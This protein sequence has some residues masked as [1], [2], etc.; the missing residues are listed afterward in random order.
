MSVG[1]ASPSLQSFLRV[2]ESEP[3]VLMRFE[4]HSKPRAGNRTFIAETCIFD[5]I[6]SHFGL[7]CSFLDV[8]E[9]DCF[10]ISQLLWSAVIFG[11]TC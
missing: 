5:A 6:S 4:A 3:V 1:R 11:L 9:I 8:N 7:L 2:T 10:L